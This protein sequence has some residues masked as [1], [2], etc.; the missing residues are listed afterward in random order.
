MNLL[1]SFLNTLAGLAFWHCHFSAE[2]PKARLFLSHSEHGE[3][4]WSAMYLTTAF[5]DF[6]LCLL[7]SNH[8]SYNCNVMSV[9][10]AMTAQT[11]TCFFLR[12]IF[13]W[14]LDWQSRRQVLLHAD[15]LFPHKIME[16]EDHRQQYL[17]GR[18]GRIY[19][20]YWVHKIKQLFHKQHQPTLLCPHH[21]P[22]A[23]KLFLST[24]RSHGRKK[25]HQLTTSIVLHLMHCVP[26]HL[27]LFQKHPVPFRRT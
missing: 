8:R 6:N 2:R 7:V 14:Q 16:E 13:H 24:T 18:Q 27:I 12:L 17:T 5:Y 20:H 26:L 1:S 25:W 4:H 9:I 3:C 11:A 19:Q 10:E 15:C 22:L 21:W 23:C